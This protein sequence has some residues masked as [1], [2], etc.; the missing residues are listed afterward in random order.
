MRNYLFVWLLIM[1]GNVVAGG[2]YKRHLVDLTVSDF[3]T[4]L[5]TVLTPLV[6]FIDYKTRKDNIKL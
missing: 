3:Q 6:F 2:T 4:F 1:L 5:F